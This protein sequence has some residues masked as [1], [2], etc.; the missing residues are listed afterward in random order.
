MRRLLPRV[1]LTLLLAAMAARHH[2]ADHGDG[3]ALHHFGPGAVAP[4]DWQKPRHDGEDRHHLRSHPL[5]RA[6]HE[7]QH[8]NHPV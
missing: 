6:G 2:A 4:H 1:A 8:E 3:N 7:S 5:D